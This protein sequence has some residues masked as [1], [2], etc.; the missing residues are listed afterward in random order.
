MSK[1]DVKRMV[2]DLNPVLSKR[3][4]ISGTSSSSIDAFSDTPLTEREIRVLEVQANIKSIVKEFIELKGE[5]K[6][7]EAKQRQAA[8]KTE[9]NE[10]FI[11]VLE[12]LLSAKQN[13]ESKLEI[14]ITRYE[15]EL[16]ELRNPITSDSGINPIL[17]PIS[18]IL[19]PIL[20]YSI[21]SYPILSYPILSYPILSYIIYY[22]FLFYFS[23]HRN[24]R[25]YDWE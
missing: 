3:T 11:E 2:T 5:I 8:N 17:Y 9:I 13:Y 22:T 6:S 1:E 21:L 10:K 12:C 25:K 4:Q 19:Y 24:F 23:I 16:K 18:Y 15:N 14:K 20:S 7:L